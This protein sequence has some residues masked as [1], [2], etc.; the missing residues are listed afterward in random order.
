MELTINPFI[1]VAAPGTAAEDGAEASCWLEPPA[2]GR[3]A[4]GDLMPLLPSCVSHTLPPL[5]GAASSHNASYP[6]QRN[7]GS[8]P[9]AVRGAG[10]L[11]DNSRYVKLVARDPPGGRWGE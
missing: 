3:W 7:G 9:P 5:G 10:P 1:L 6:A 8:A 4:G 2:G 11:L